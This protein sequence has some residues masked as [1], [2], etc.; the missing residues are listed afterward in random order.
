MRIYT[1]AFGENYLGMAKV[2]A[3]SVRENWPAAKFE[4]IELRRPERIK[5]HPRHTANWVQKWNAWTDIVMQAPKEADGIILMDADMLVLKPMESAFEDDF[6]VCATE[7]PSNC[8]ISTGVIFV[9]PTCGA[10]RMFAAVQEEISR[11]LANKPELMKLNHTHGGIDQSAYYQVAT[12]PGPW[13]AALL[14]SDE[15]NLTNFEHYSENDTLAVHYWGR[16]KDLVSQAKC[17][18]KTDPAILR[19]LYHKWNFYKERARYYE[20]NP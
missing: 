1:V 6:D 11:L 17:W 19:L 13:A 12:K 2:L 15:Y 4:L 20:H 8:P 7:Q 18:R 5:G 14:P 9:R 3:A 16:L 10:Q